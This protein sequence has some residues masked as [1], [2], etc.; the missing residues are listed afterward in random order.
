M[1]TCGNHNCA[2]S[3]FNNTLWHIQQQYPGSWCYVEPTGALLVQVPMP[4][5]C[6]MSAVRPA[7]F[8]CKCWLGFIILH[9]LTIY[10]MNIEWT[11]QQI[12]EVRSMES[13]SFAA[14]GQRFVT[15]PSRFVLLGGWVQ[16]SSSTSPAPINGSWTEHCKVWWHGRGGCIEG[17]I[18]WIQLAGVWC[19]ELNPHP[20]ANC[21]KLQL[22]QAISDWQ[23]QIVL[24]HITTIFIFVLIHSSGLVPASHRTGIV[25][26]NLQAIGSST[27]WRSRLPESWNA[28]SFRRV[29]RNISIHPG[30]WAAH[31]SAV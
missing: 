20:V 31:G 22:Q 6:F 3:I 26:W 18:R 9:H 25:M 10:R 28:K 4:K 19:V 11:S 5:I 23:Y 17:G 24:Q 2:E 1:H 29:M 12:P 7:L 14:C 30:Q 27:T 8:S 13:I 21:R 16:P 15:R